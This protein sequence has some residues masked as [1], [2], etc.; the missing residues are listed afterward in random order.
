MW[1]NGH[2]FFY[3]AVGPFVRLSNPL[4][5]DSTSGVR[6]CGACVSM[7]QIPLKDQ[8]ARVD[9]AGKWGAVNSMF[10]SAVPPALACLS[11]IEK[12]LVAMLCPMMKIRHL[13]KGGLK[14]C[15][16]AISLRQPT[17]RIVTAL[18]RRMHEA[19]FL[20]VV[21]GL[22]SED[23]RHSVSRHTRVWRVRCQN[24][25]TALFGF[26]STVLRTGTFP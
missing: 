11:L 13:K 25:R 10:P 23:D 22:V 16:N 6:R 18:S 17:G 8:T 19:G 4:I 7:E 26:L 9:V 20:F 21:R 14:L 3:C 2:F 12:M 5:W 24:V 15:G 1:S